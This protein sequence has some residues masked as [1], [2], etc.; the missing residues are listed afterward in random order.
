[1][2][3]YINPEIRERLIRDGKLLRINNEGQE[4]DMADAPGPGLHVNLM[5][6]IPLPL[7]RGNVQPT[8]RWYASVR[9][10]ELTEV[11]H[12]ASKLREQGAFEKLP[13][14]HFIGAISVGIIDGEVV[15]DLDYIKDSNAET[16]MNLVMTEHGEFIEIQGTAERKPFTASELSSIIEQGSEAIASIIAQQKQVLGYTEGE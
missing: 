1:M 6:P 7:A 12:L 15:V 4:V 3:T 5:G 9:S 16:D 11:E 14:I 2:F 8:V 10:T 13:L